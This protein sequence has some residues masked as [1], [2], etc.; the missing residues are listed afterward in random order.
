MEQ[1]ETLISIFES[2]GMSIDVDDKHAESAIKNIGYYKLKEYATPF[3]VDGDYSKLRLS[4]VIRRYYYDKNLRMHLLHTSEIIELAFKNRM[5][6]VLGDYGEEFGYLNFTSWADIDE[7][8]IEHI[9]DNQT[10]CKNEIKKNAK[11]SNKVDLTDDQNMISLGNKLNNPD[12]S[13]AERTSKFPTVWLALDLLSFGQAYNMYKIMKPE[14]KERVSDTFNC[15]QG[16]LDSWLG[17][18]VLLRNMSAHNNNLVD[19]Q[20][21]TKPKVLESW[22]E[23]MYSYTDEKGKLIYGNKL[24]SALL[25]IL[26]LTRQVDKEYGFGELSTDC[27]KLTNAV[28]D[29]GTNQAQALGFISKNKMKKMFQKYSNSQEKF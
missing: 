20:L 18:I 29:N 12:A 15:S 21:K 1:W 19:I 28:R 11:K 8:T 7:Y 4:A 3:M 10:Y 25:P 22:Q 24:A 16:Q 23:I 26:Y 2:R 27:S 13:K 9:I 5:S 17:T 6:E 14:L